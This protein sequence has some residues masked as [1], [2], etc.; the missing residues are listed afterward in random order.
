M[1]SATVA[2]NSGAEQATISRK[3]G[4]RGNGR[5]LRRAIDDARLRQQQARADLMPFDPWR[6]FVLARIDAEIEQY[7]WE[8]GTGWTGQPGHGPR[9]PK[10]MPPPARPGVP[11]RE[12]RIITSLLRPW[13]TGPGR[14][15]RAPVHYAQMG[16]RS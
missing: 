9:L 14:G 15:H 3:R 13:A 4:R 6:G 10:T 11:P 1:A 5:R 8:L 7:K 16:A 2:T 12:V